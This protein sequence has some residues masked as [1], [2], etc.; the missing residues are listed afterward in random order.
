DGIR[1]WS[2]T[3]VQTCALPICHAPRIRQRSSSNFPAWHWMDHFFARLPEGH[4]LPGPGRRLVR[5]A[6]AGTR[7]EE[8]AVVLPPGGRP[9]VRLRRA[10]GLLARGRRWGGPGDV[11]HPDHVAQ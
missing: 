8:A 1:D 3:G 10:V 4:P 7:P 5:V 9:A 6:A 11:C 2:V